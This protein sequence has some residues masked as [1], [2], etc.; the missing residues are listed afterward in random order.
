MYLLINQD[1]EL[2]EQSESLGIVLLEASVDIEESFHTKGFWIE[3]IFKRRKMGFVQYEIRKTK[4]SNE[5]EYTIIKDM[6]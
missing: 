3:P 5:I 6:V 1:G 2:I 4:C